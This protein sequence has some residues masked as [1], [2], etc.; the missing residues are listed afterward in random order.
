MLVKFS[1]LSQYLFTEALNQYIGYF[2]KE[3]NNYIV[4]KSYS[5]I[6]KILCYDFMQQKTCDLLC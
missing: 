5:Q 6:S 2:D 3:L 1:I 4:T